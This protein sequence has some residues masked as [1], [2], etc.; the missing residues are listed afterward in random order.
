MESEITTH[1][2]D[3][4][5]LAT[6]PIG[7]YE[8]GDL[9]YIEG[10]NTYYRFDPA[11]GKPVDGVN[12]VST[13]R[14]PAQAGCV[15]AV[16]TD[17]ARWILTNLSTGSAAVSA[18]T[19]LIAYAPGVVSPVFPVFNDWSLVESYVNAHQGCVRLIVEQ[20]GLPGFLHVPST[21]NLDGRGR[22]EIVGAGVNGEAEIVI[23]DGGQIKN[24][25]EWRTVV[26]RTAPTIRP[27][28][29]YD[30]D[31]IVW[32]GFDATFLFSGVC[33]QPVIQIN[34]ASYV[35]I[36]FVGSSEFRNSHNPGKAVMNVANPIT[37]L[38]GIGELF[39]PSSFDSTIAG[40]VGANLSLQLD[41]SLPPTISLPAW[42]GAIS[43]TQIDM[44]AGTAYPPGAPANWPAPPPTNVQ[45]ALD[46]LALSA[47]RVTPVKTAAYGPAFGEFVRVDPTA[48]GFTITLPAIAPANMGRSI[49]VKNVSPSANVV[50]IAATGGNAIDG[51]AS[52]SLTG[53]HAELGF[54]SDGTGGWMII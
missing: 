26:V 25:R 50:T 53:A 27:S 4:C 1:L 51:A 32:E 42:P 10:A 41:S 2:P 17:P 21:A 14:G 12:I 23:D 37:A 52:A 13:P 39:F 22:L 20:T 46:E 18:S 48:G 44:A 19:S 45:Q 33:T 30:I 43:V 16:G 3:V 35:G 47:F 28:I 15:K 9:V 7:Q 5:A 8:P 29:V 36:L 11:S 49:L 31:G 54:V 34:C 40:P 6:Q 24:V 38:L